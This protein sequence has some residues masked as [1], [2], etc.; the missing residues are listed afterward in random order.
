[1]RRSRQPLPLPQPAAPWDRSAPRRQNPLD[2]VFG[3]FRFAVG[4]LAGLR[5]VAGIGAGQFLHQLFGRLGALRG[6][7]RG[8]PLL[9]DGFAALFLFGGPAGL[10][11][12]IALFGIFEEIIGLADLGESRRGIGIVAIGVRMDGFRLRAPGGLDFLVA[13]VTFYAEDRIWI[14][15]AK[16]QL[17][18]L[19]RCRPSW[20]NPETNPSEKGCPR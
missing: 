6:L 2:D 4:F 9:H 8:F 14:A 15:H 11:V 13:G 10:V 20:R 18:W 7:A 3:G 12:E 5:P 16:H 1:M 17:R 19:R